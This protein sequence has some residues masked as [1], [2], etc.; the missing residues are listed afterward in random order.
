M[1]DVR[2]NFVHTDSRT[3]YIGGMIDEESSTDFLEGLLELQ[4]IPHMPIQVLINSVGGDIYEAMAIYEAISLSRCKVNGLVLGVCMSAAGLILQACT[5]R[6]ISRNSIFMLHDGT[7]FVPRLHQREARTEMKEAN[8]LHKQF[9]KLLISRTT[10]TPA[11]HK[12]L[13]SF[14]T[15][16]SPEDAVKYGFA[17]AILTKENNSWIK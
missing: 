14:A 16:L 5:K 15:Y 2:T 9:A 7:S 17:D 10:L 12:K 4:Q 13:S 3:L 8:R 1:G 11:K 6:F